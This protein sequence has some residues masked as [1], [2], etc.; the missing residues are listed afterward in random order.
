MLTIKK[1]VAP[2]W[3]WMLTCLTLILF[4]GCTDPGPRALL[5]GERL[6]RE[7]KSPEAIRKLEQ[8]S[9][10]LPKD[11]R[12]WN[13]LG[14]AYHGAGRLSEAV[15]AY[16]Q[17]L[18]LD[19]NLAA[20]HY[21]LGCLHLEQNDLP[22]ALAELT[23]YTGFQP[24]APDGWTRLGTAQ[25]RAR[26]LDAAEKS[27]HQALK[28]NAHS[29]EAWNG[30]GLV[31]MQRRHYPDAYQ[32]FNSAL[33]AQPDYAPALLNAA[34]V[35]HQYLNGRASA[36]EKYRQYL[37]LCP[38]VANSA[39]MHQIVNQLE[40]EL[41]PPARVTPTH[42]PP[43]IASLAPPGPGSNSPSAEAGTNK[44]PALSSPLS[45][46]SIVAHTNA[47][48]APPNRL[49]TVTS[50]P[51]PQSE[52]QPVRSPKVEVVRLSE[53]EPI[54]AARDAGL[55]AGAGA[56]DPIPPRPALTSGT[57]A[58]A[59]IRPTANPGN[60]FVSRLNPRNWFRSRE[61][62]P[63]SVPT[64]SGE[65]I[66]D[67]ET[68]PAKTVAASTAHASS[69]SLAVPRYRYHSPAVPKPGNRAEA[70]RR[71]AQGVRAQERN[72]LSEAIEEYHQAT[73]ADPSFFDGHYNLGVAAYE[74]GDLP[75]CLWSYEYALAINPVSVKARFNLALA[76]QKANYP[77]D[78]AAELEKLLADNPSE[79]RAHVALANLYAQQLGQPARARE[80]Y[81][82]LLEL[83][84]QHPQATAIRYWLEANP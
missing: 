15:K 27:F 74:A 63:P 76:L 17:A 64:G 23:S 60:G 5:E 69:P 28:L 67:A 44:P 34:I 29:A 39:A 82:R 47:T 37:A 80:H 54:K 58:S 71:L 6:L 12:A 75:Q 30:L 51:P 19:R 50:P 35:A 32:Q 83:D 78:A 62:T 22:A 4:N 20:G 43:Q 41:H 8:A 48:A 45:T 11:A 53:E 10:L 42:A 57:T 81:L 21:N 9:N 79:A 25:L 73:S 24:N 1:L 3:V 16:Q 77:G 40:L 84:P 61:K 2:S 56:P 46:G 66:A 31:Q 52:A 59:N 18:A 65:S 7:G 26:Q 72:R 13:H 70:E 14:V 36:L 55:D 33:R 49:A 38:N 68:K